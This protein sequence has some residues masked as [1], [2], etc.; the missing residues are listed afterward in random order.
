MKKRLLSIFLILTAV[1][2]LPGCGMISLTDSEE[3]EIAMYSASVVRKYNKRQDQAVSYFG[4][5]S[6]AVY[7]KMNSKPSGTVESNESIPVDIS[8]ASGAEDTSDSVTENTPSIAD[9]N[10]EEKSLD[11][12]IG[13]SGLTFSSS[14]VS[15]IDYYTIEGIMELSPKE[16]DRFMEVTVSCTNT[17][18]S[19]IKVDFSALN[20]T[21]SCTFAGTTVNSSEGLALDGLSSY[22]GTIKAGSTQNLVLLF[23]F[24]SDVLSGDLEGYIVKAKSDSGTYRVSI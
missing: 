7:E 3:E 5:K 19:D 14:G 20:I 10:L 11:E 18:D 13:I 4:E 17:T 1:L 24:S 6:R 21:Y 9:S 2:S 23:D 15:A 16:G 22:S 8:N 12:I